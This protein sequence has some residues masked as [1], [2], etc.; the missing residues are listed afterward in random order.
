MKSY[1]NLKLLRTAVCSSI[2]SLFVLAASTVYA[3]PAAP[4]PF[5]D[6]QPDGAAVTLFVRGDEHFNW[7]EDTEGYTVVKNKGWFEYA[8]IGPSGRLNPNGMIVGRDNPRA[9][10]LQKRILPS[11]AIRAQ[12]ARKVNGVSTSAGVSAAPDATAPVGNVK[13]LVVMIRFS[14]H[15]GRTLP[16]VS[17]VD[18]L[19]NSTGGHPTLAPTGSVK[20][21]YLENSYGQ[22]TLNSDINPGIGDWIT[23]PNT[24]AYYANGNSGDST[25]WQALRSALD[26]LDAVIDFND[27][28][29]DNDGRIDSI[30]FIHSGYGAEWGG[31]DAYGGTTANRIWSHRWAI[32]PQWNSN[33][34]VSVFDYHISPGVWGTSGSDIGRIGVIAHE[35][36]HFFGLPDL[37]DTDSG[38]GDGIGSWGM[39]ANSWGFDGSQ[40]CPPHFSPWS[41]IDLGWSTPVVISQPGQY[42]VNQAETNADIYRINSGFPSNEYLLIENRQN[43]GFDCAIPQGGIAIWHIDDSAG[44]NTQGYPGQSG[45]PDNGNHYRV[46]LLQADGNYNLERGNNRGD[47]TDMHHAAGIDAIGP[48]PGNHPNTDT[49]QNG[50]VNVTGI[51]ISDISA[52]SASMTFCFNG[53]NGVPSPSGLTATAQSKNNISLAWSDNSTG[54]DGFHIESSSNGT[55]WSSL[56]TLGSNVTAYNNINLLPDSTWYY[57]VRAF[58]AAE[59]SAWSNTANATTFD[60]SPAAPTGL[61]ATAV[62]D[63]R[64]NLN[65]V[66]QAGNE[67]GYRVER[68][69]NG[70]T[71]WTAIAS[72]LNANSTSY[73]NTGLA[74]STEYFYRVTGFNSS[75]DSLNYSQVAAAT[76]QDPPPYVDY[77]AQSQ[78]ASEGGVSGS[79]TNTH[80]DDDSV[81]SITEQESGGNPSRRRSSLSHRWTFNIVA[82]NSTTLTTNAWSSGSGD[83]DNF[84]FQYST[85]GS[86]YTNALLVS[87]TAPSNTQSVA[88][89]ANLSGTVYIQVIDTDNS[90][91][92][93]ALDTV[94][95]D[96][97]VIRVDNT[98]VTPPN[99]PSALSATAIEYNQVNISWSDNS[100]D[101]TGFELQ[102]ATNGGSFST[103]WTF[104]AGVTSFSDNSVS[105]LTTYQYR[106]RALKGATQ[107]GFSN[108]GSATTP[109]QPAGSA[110]NLSASGFK[111]KGRQ[112]VDLSWSGSSASFVE[113]RRNGSVINASTINDGFYNDNIG[114]KG[115]ATYRYEVCDAGTSNCSN[116]VTI[117]F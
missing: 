106:A 96:H 71:G 86:S 75:P 55:N 113:I 104:G 64:I 35:T 79:Y 39:M 93:R 89:P 34:G 76:T 32:Q 74:P 36:G 49:Y 47:S 48:G 63:S 5:T 10:G 42:V 56:V 60:S 68:S 59:N 51:T 69:A 23:V 73:S 25:L 67:D 116:A 54:E 21:V 44:F 4:V 115:G 99:D 114:A 24:E 43:A 72:N 52:S 19:F 82:G 15:V 30:A 53:C 33:D 90:Q 108:I 78:S 92:A 110:I 80:N 16:S 61:N 27:Y 66:D 91:G 117:T 31:T 11:Q 97:L 87:S 112:Q 50:N 84:Q 85:D 37:Y 45:W 81:Q 12:S 109:E 26:T 22:M 57:R 58:E 107:S 111:V 8:E 17:D 38:A 88:L 98:P 95:I 28:D 3:I 105:E 29:L 103:S 46:A 40:L 41:K 65:W 18:V 101:E 100:S 14:D 62:S 1:R 2:F 70:S 77:I 20:D 102:R 9:R 83:G 6:Q 13:N 7:M 94:Y